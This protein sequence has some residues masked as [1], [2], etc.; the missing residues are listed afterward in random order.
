MSETSKVMRLVALRPTGSG[1]LDRVRFVRAAKGIQLFGSASIT[2]DERQHRYATHISLIPLQRG[3]GQVQQVF[4]VRQ[5]LP[6]FPAW[7]VSESKNDPAGKAPRLAITD[8]GGAIHSLLEMEGQAERTINS[9]TSFKDYLSP[10]YLRES[11]DGHGNVLT[12]QIGAE[13]AVFDPIPEA[14]ADSARQILP[15]IGD[16][17]IAVRNSKGIVVFYKTYKGEAVRGALTMPGILH[18]QPV[19]A[20]FKPSGAS[21]QPFGQETIYEFDADARPE[22]IALVGTTKEGFVLADGDFNRPDEEFHLLLHQKYET[23]L[24]SPAIA[25]SPDRVS[26]AFLKKPAQTEADLLVG[27]SRLSDLVKTP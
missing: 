3:E 6:G 12:V 24:F 1:P 21:Y 14:P 13:A 2:V 26:V 16:G 18:A 9:P 25:A 5:L 15:K 7:D 23:E 27:I 22:S 19:D 17:L 20:K 11:G 10:R 8:F 4:S